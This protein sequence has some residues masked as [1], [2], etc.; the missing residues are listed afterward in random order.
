M[1]RG[2]LLAR[3][4]G[5]RGRGIHAGRRPV[6]WRRRAMNHNEQFYIGGRW[7]EPARPATLD[8][9]DPSTEQ[10][11]TR[12]SV[13]SA[14]DVDRAVASARAAFESYSATSRDE[15]LALMR[16]ILD[17]YMSRAEDLAEAVS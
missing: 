14:A 3:L 9:I 4:R 7:V 17:R 16:R 15:R 10:P 1:R 13:G 12:I 8:V 6:A 2:A 5:P 11:F